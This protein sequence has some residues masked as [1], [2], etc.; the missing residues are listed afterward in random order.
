MTLSRSPDHCTHTPSSTTI[1]L[2]AERSL[3]D[4][5]SQW[6]LVTINYVPINNCVKS[7]KIPSFSGQS[8]VEERVSLCCCVLRGK[9]CADC[10]MIDGLVA[11]CGERLSSLWKR[12]DGGT[13]LYPPPTLHVSINRVYVVFLNHLFTPNIVCKN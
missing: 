2:Y 1:I 9:F 11:Q 6:T 12:D 7:G 8:L 4:W 13:G 10:L 3:P 5:P